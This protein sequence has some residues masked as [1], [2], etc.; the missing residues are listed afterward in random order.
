MFVMYFAAVTW[1][2]VC[3]HPSDGSRADGSS[4]QDWTVAQSRAEY[5]EHTQAWTCLPCLHLLHG[6]NPHT[7]R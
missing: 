7:A 6:L 5:R 1:T 4:R 3:Y 2:N